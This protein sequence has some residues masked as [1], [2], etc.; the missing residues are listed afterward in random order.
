[1]RTKGARIL[2]RPEWFFKIRENLK[3][4]RKLEG[5]FFVLIFNSELYGKIN[6]ESIEKFAK[7]T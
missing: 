1:M 2:E 3:G 6:H 4:T 5:V 7:L